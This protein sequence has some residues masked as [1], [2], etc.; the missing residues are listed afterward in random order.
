MKGEGETR[1]VR[2]MIYRQSR[3]LVSVSWLLLPLLLVLDGAP[4]ADA[5]A[6]PRGTTN[7]RESDRKMRGSQS[8]SNIMR[9]D[10]DAAHGDSSDGVKSNGDPR[11]EMSLL[12]FVTMLPGTD[13]EAE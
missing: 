7:G 3:D 5:V 12:G 2:L 1:M 9:D 4:L 10:D 8:S 13:E 6:G 11:Y